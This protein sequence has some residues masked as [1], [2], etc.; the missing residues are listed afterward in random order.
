M[1]SRLLPLI[2]ALLCCL[3]A[4]SSALP[5]AALEAVEC[6]SES[7]VLINQ[8]TGR[9]VLSKNADLPRPPA[10]LTKIVTAMLTITLCDDPAGTFVTVPDGIYDEITAVGG[11]VLPLV[12]GETLSVLDLLYAVM[13]PSAC[14]ACMVLAHHFGGGD[15]QVF[16]DKMNEYAAHAGAFSTRFVNPHGLDAP[17][18]LSTARDISLL[19]RHA[20]QNETFNRIIQTKEYIIPEND[21][22]AKRYV[23]YRTTIPML[24]TDG[25]D[26]Y[27]ELVG[28]KSGY[29]LAAGLCLSSM[30]R[31]G[32][33]SFLAVCMGAPRR[34]E[35]GKNMARVDTL[36]L[37]NWAFSSFTL[38]TLA[39]AGTVYKTVDLEGAHTQSAAIILREDLVALTAVGSAPPTIEVDAPDSFILP[40]ATDLAGKVLVVQDEQVIATADL[41]FDATPTAAVP[42]PDLPNAPAPQGV[43]LI[44]LLGALLVLF[45]FVLFFLGKKKGKRRN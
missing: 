25:E 27:P 40:V 45:I 15:V 38:E 17:A 10:S 32:E 34:Q 3:A 30:A 1:K 7:V 2:L 36:N 43:I 19:L 13:L 16:V 42:E 12:P 4:A 22:S 28:I 26:Y 5:A 23:N 33:L 6:A 8:N 37:Y 14:D 44:L 29:T 21:F 18:H 11:A 31:S 20:L 41:Y 24:Y 39:P 9:V 35:D